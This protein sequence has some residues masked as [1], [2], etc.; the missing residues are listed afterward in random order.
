[1]T[2]K[3]MK[4]FVFLFIFSVSLL[5]QA[6]DTDLAY[7]KT[8]FEA[9]ANENFQEK[10][11]VHMDRPGY[12]TGEIMW[13][14][15]N[16]MD[17]I[18]H[19]PQ[20]ISKVVYIEVVNQDNKPV[21]Q[22][23]IPMQDGFGNGSLYLPMTLSSGVYR[24]RAYT[25]WMKNYH[26]HYF[27]EKDFTIVNGFIQPEFKQTKYQ[28]NV[29]IQF[30][31]EGGQLVNGIK[32]KI[33]FRAVDTNGN[34][35]DFDGALISN[36]QD[37][38]AL[39]T[40]KKFG[41]GYF[42]FTP[43]DSTKISAV[44]KT[45]SDTLNVGAF[46]SSSEKGYVMHL[47]AE[48]NNLEITVNSN[49]NIEEKVY[50]LIHTRNQLNVIE[51]QPI[52]NGKALF[53]IKTDQ[54]GEGISHI[55]VF[56]YLKKPVCERLYFRY[57]KQGPAISLKTD[58]Q[59]YTSREK[60][61]LQ[62][63]IENINEIGTF[64]PAHLSM[65]VYQADAINI[66][67]EENILS[68]VWLA[69]DLKGKVESPK[70]YFPKGS[71]TEVREAIDNLM[72]THGWRKFSWENILSE[73]PAKLHLPEYEG[74]IVKALVSNAS[75]KEPVTDF[76]FFLSAP[77]SLGHIYGAKSNK[78]GELHFVTNNLLGE[79]NIIIQPT[80]GA[81][82]DYKIQSPFS[83]QF[84]TFPYSNLDISPEHRPEIQSRY[85]GMQTENIYW[86]DAR[87]T[88]NTAVI[89]TVTFYDKIDKQ[90]LLDNYTRFPTM[91]E[92]MK[93]YVSE[94][95]VRKQDNRDI[96]RII[97]GKQDVHSQN[98]L[99]LLDNIPI[100]DITNVLAFNPIKIEKIEII[101]DNFIFEGGIPVHGV[102]N[103]KTYD[104]DAMEE[105]ALDP[106]LFTTAYEG[107]QIPRTY[108]APMYGDD[109]KGNNPK[110]DFRNLLYWAPNITLE[111]NEIKNLKFYTSDR[112]GSYMGVVEGIGEDGAL[113]Y[114][115]FTFSVDG[116]L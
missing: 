29:D 87:N 83:D 62:V 19:Q 20:H 18:H 13:F 65:A 72:L 103:Y 9:Y 78:K 64:T 33:A 3:L 27:Y 5:G 32:S 50:L 30:F 107:H 116:A 110:P 28:K 69:S 74:H 76:A 63:S 89:D 21:I 71:T 102:I 75:S 86:L 48:K 79:K 59:S 97:K 51:E 56:N 46:P 26:P 49:L 31:P 95:I 12:L 35:I 93:E 108:Y 44:V 11:Y 7:L 92:V 1:M 112:K 43:S 60:V 55:T 8:S 66:E 99:I 105:M 73:Q 84:S 67:D 6:Q 96:F 115:T 57:P 14:K 40:P 37:T 25:N 98:P 91:K 80:N 39:F 54:L 22:T 109:I 23:K 58:K 17:A 104:G 85:V 61:D 52:T 94:V 70:Y 90:Y 47:I 45:K 100:F 81:L 42:Y 10:I 24:I 82:Y 53:S 101:K 36:Q 16:L 111:T 15:I 113:F 68:Y 106:R 41:I 114:K 4:P 77:G 2:A 38:I 88:I 34:G